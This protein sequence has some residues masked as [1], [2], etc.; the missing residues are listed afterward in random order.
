MHVFHYD[1]CL[2]DFQRLQGS[3]RIPKSYPAPHGLQLYVDHCFFAGT[4]ISDR[5]LNELQLVVE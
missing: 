1:F 2:F 3:P 4:T 5:P